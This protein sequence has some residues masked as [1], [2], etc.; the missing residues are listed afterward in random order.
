MSGLIIRN[1]SCKSPEIMVPLFIALIRPIIEYAN[2]VWCPFNKYNIIKLEKVQ[3][4]F[5][6]RINGMYKLSYPDRLIK[7][8]LPSLEYRRLRGDLIETYKIINNIYDPLTTVSLLTLDS[9][10]R[11]RT[12]GYKLEKTDQRENLMGIFLQ[13]E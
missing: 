13:I 10:T 12:N 8:K 3:Q 9:N 4:Q 5:T 1:I 11:T 7:L 2:V 6:K